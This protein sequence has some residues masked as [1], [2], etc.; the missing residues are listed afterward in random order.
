MSTHL[1][2]FSTTSAPSGGAPSP[3]TSDH[4][5]IDGA[6]YPDPVVKIG[7]KQIHP[8]GAHGQRAKCPIDDGK[9]RSA[10]LAHQQ[11]QTSVIA[12][13]DGRRAPH[14]PFRPR[15]PGKLSLTKPAWTGWPAQGKPV[16]PAHRQ[17]LRASGTR[18]PP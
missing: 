17:H 12:K 9:Q 11:G 14:R 6:P 15:C 13:N 5:A 4:E 18:T 7:P 3:A 16:V 2:R 8:F 1:L 10:T